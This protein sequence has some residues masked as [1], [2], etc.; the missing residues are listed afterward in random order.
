MRFF[1]ELLVLIEVKLTK[2]RRVRL[3]IWSKHDAIIV[4]AMI[5]GKYYWDTHFASEETEI[6][7]G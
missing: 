6:L 7:R 3:G 2:D 5:R 1:S 4:T